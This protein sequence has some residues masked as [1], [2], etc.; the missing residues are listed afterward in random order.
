MVD[1]ADKVDDEEEYEVNEEEA[2]YW[3]K[4]ARKVEQKE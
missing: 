4:R 3:V 2:K 1:K